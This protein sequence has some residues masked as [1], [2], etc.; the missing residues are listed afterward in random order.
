M[1]PNETSPDTGASPRTGEKAKSAAAT[2][3]QGEAHKSVRTQKHAS[4]SAF[5]NTC[6]N[7]IQSKEMLLDIDNTSIHWRLDSNVCILTSASPVKAQ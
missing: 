2:Q 3:Y 1:A 5:N 7:N 4:S 6:N